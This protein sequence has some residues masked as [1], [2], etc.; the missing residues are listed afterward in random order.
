MSYFCSNK[1]FPPQF[2]TFIL[3]TLSLWG[4][5]MYIPHSW[6]KYLRNDPYFLSLSPPSVLSS[7]VC[8]PGWVTSHHFPS[9]NLSTLAVYSDSTHSNLSTTSHITGQTQLIILSLWSRL[10]K[11]KDSVFNLEPVQHISTDLNF[12]IGLLE[13]KFQLHHLQGTWTQTSCKISLS[14]LL[15]HFSRVRLCV[16]P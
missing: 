14:V 15:S 5:N 4:E 1:T 12:G 11:D 10:P 13:L 6:R 16:T 2:I 9:L 3:G 7:N 8:F